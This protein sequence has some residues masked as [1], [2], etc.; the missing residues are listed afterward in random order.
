ML[1]LKFA[2]I[3]VED[4]DKYSAFVPRQVYAG[5]FEKLG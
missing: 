3:W 2:S 4:L 5:I 1:N